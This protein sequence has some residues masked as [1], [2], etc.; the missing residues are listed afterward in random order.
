MTPR[1]RFPTTPFPLHRDLA[2]DALADSVPLL[3]RTTTVR[4][5]G[6]HLRAMAILSNPTASLEGFS[7]RSRQCIERLV[8]HRGEV[9]DL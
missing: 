2:D 4:P 5:Q 1:T 7:E 9:V 3:S 6:P 8:A